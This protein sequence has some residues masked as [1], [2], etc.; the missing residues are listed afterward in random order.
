MSGVLGIVEYFSVDEYPYVAET[1]GL[2][3]G[4]PTLGCA[5]S[6]QSAAMFLENTDYDGD[7]ATPFLFHI[8]IEDY[9]ASE[10]ITGIEDTQW[11]EQYFL[12]ASN[13]LMDVFFRPGCSQWHEAQCSHLIVRFNLPGHTEVFIQGAEVGEP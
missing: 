9:R 11:E 5:V 13:E 4:E 8:L 6:A 1:L 2:E 10:E 7:P 3:V 12:K